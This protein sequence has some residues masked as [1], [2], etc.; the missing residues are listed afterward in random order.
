MGIGG[1]GYP[2]LGLKSLLRALDEG[3]T[4]EWVDVDEIADDTWTASVYETGTIAPLTPDTK[5]EIERLGLHPRL[6][7]KEMEVALQELANYAGV[8]IGA[9]VP[10][11][12]GGDSTPFPLVASARLGLPV[13]DGD[14]C[15]RAVPEEMQ[16]TPYL[17]EK[18]I[19]PFVSVDRWGNVCILKDAA[20]F[21]TVE[22]IQKMLSVAAYGSCHLADTL[23]PAKEMKEIVIRD[24]LTYSF[25]LGAAVREARMNGEDPVQ[26][27]VDFTRGWLLFTGEVERKE[28][29][30]REGYM[31][32][33]TWVNGT[34]DSTGHVFRFWF[35]NEN[36][37][38]WLDDE[39]LVTTPDLIAVL[40]RSTGEGRINT[41]I[42]P[43]DHVAVVGI[44][45][46]EVFRSER[47]LS[48]AGPRHFGFE[49]DYVP[50]EERMTT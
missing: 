38:C 18:N 1:G 3:L 15:G 22:R 20:N 23:L 34:G 43:G 4:I 31:W 11:E 9:V 10:V 40:D 27:V 19:H 24:T 33:T 28:W 6:A 35:K 7:G 37:V 29:E 12:L 2:E 47:G 48:G 14:Y 26:A 45:G 21:Y 30:D 16:G 5:A 17:Y 8:T 32:G 36:H 13:V 42:E 41:N 46:P 50:I 25:E 44:K 49:I 39:P